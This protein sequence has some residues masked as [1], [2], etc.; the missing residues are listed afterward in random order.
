MAVTQAGSPAPTT[1]AS[2]N[3]D[4]VAGTDRS[5][6][7]PQPDHATPTGSVVQSYAFANL[8]PAVSSAGLRAFVTNSSVSAFYSPAN[9][10]G[11]IFV[12][13]FCDGTTWRVG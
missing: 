5:I 2:S 12:P 6:Q 4:G 7:G 10:S 9:G 11:A 3:T 13:V 1:L 8:P